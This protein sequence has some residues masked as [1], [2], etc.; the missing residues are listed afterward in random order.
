MSASPVRTRARAASTCLLPPGY[1]GKVPEGYF[2]VRAQTFSVW[3]AWRSFLVDGDPKPGVDLVKKFTRIY[4]LSQADNPPTPKFVDVSNKA[5]NTVAPADYS[6]WEAL[7]QVVQE[8]PTDSIDP[9]TLGFWAAVGIRKGKPFAP[10]ER[11]KKILT[12]AAPVGDATARAIMYRWRKLTGTTTRT[13]PGA[14]GS[15]AATSSRKTGHVCWTRT[16]LLLLR[17]R[18]HAGYGYK[19]GGRR[20]AIHGGL[21]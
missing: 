3:I 5:F 20:L 19:D 10:D 9:T 16:G 1:K 15:S 8:E 18:C 2:V 14:W 7:N 13:V 11:M 6:F 17:H 21:R 4:P 12:E